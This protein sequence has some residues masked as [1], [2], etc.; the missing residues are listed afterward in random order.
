MVV[1]VEK[2]PVTARLS[3]LSSATAMRACGS[4]AEQAGQVDQRQ[5]AGLG[6]GLELRGK[7]C[8]GSPAYGRGGDPCALQYPARQ[9]C[10]K[11]ENIAHA[12]AVSA[13][14]ACCLFMRAWEAL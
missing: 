4:L 6:V 5:M 12:D 2:A 11:E 1:D 3:D 13:S 14:A 7:T 9:L 8:N 10:A